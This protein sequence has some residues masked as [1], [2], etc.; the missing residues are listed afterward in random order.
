L[1]RRAVVHLV[2]VLGPPE[3]S[4]DD[5]QALQDGYGVGAALGREVRRQIWSEAINKLLDDHHLS[6]AETGYLSDLQVTLALTEA[7]VEATRLKA[8]APRFRKRTRSP[9][10]PS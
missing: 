5:V 10:A 6:R 1:F 3:V 9:P 2:Q 7:E 4:P 8:V